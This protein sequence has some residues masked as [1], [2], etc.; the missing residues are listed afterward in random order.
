MITISF[1]PTLPIKTLIESIAPY[2]LEDLTSSETECL[3]PMTVSP[4]EL[5]SCVGESI[6][7]LT[8][9]PSVTIVFPE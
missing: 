9:G 7:K 3:F 2:S 4:I 8:A 1:T 5:I 6:S